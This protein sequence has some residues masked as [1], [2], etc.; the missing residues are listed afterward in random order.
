MLFVRPDYTSQTDPITG[1]RKKIYI[2]S[3][4]EDV[5]KGKILQAFDDIY[6]DGKDYV[7]VCKLDDSSQ[8]R[9]KL[10]S[11]ING[12]GLERFYKERTEKG[13][14]VAKRQDLPAMLDGLFAD[15]DKKVSLYQQ[16]KNGIELKKINKHTAWETLRF[17][18]EMIQQIRNTGEETV[19]RDNDFI[20]SPVRDENGNHFDS[21]IYWDKKQQKEKVDL[22][23]S[24]DANGAYNIARKGIIVNE[25]IKR[26]LKL[27]IKDDEWDAW[28]AG[29]E[30]WEKWI[31]NNM[32]DLKSEKKKS[33]K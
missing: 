11:G 16:I 9:W 1:W 8:K 4:S 10:Y 32:K 30:A 15:F 18:I 29:E 3:G 22:P 21:R 31:K 6:F 12:K 19:A 14:W 25:H 20:L 27:Y 5:V 7:F 17:V 2:G 26:G 23:G 33:K 24:G 13:I 28:L